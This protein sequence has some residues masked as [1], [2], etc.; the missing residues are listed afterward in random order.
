MH[1]AAIKQYTS[2]TGPRLRTCSE[3]S[4]E[5]GFCVGEEVFFG[6][7][8]GMILKHRGGTREYP[9]LLIGFPE[10]FNR[11][12]SLGSLQLL[13]KPSEITSEI[14][15]MKGISVGSRIKTNCGSE[16]WYGYV[17]AIT[18]FHCA[19]SGPYVTV[20]HESLTYD[21]A[22]S[23]LDVDLVDGAPLQGFP[24]FLV[25]QYPTQRDVSLG[26]KGFLAGNVLRYCECNYLIERYFEG[27]VFCLS[28]SE[29]RWICATWAE[30]ITRHH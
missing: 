22:C 5:R 7:S 26:N 18:D 9:R 6:G 20:R 10:G 11:I 14:L 12:C 30:V 16:A 2:H 21:L 15:S 3:V 13:R 27:N 1:K 24:N 28:G 17:I 4:I 25:T 19:R 29:R 23:C 8:R